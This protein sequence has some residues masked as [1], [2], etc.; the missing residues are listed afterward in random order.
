MTPRRSPTRP[1]GGSPR[2]ID[3][4]D[5]AI[6]DAKRAVSL[7]ADSAFGCLAIADIY[8]V[9]FWNPEEALTHAQKAIRLDPRHLEN[10]R[11][12]E[13][14]AYNQMKRYAEAVDA[15]KRGQRKVILGSILTWSSH[16]LNWVASKRREPRRRK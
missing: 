13:G 1:L 3:Q 7:D 10:Y 5:Q 15:L 11:L 16:I 14:V 9:F 4:P 12:E 8:N 2:C 6:T